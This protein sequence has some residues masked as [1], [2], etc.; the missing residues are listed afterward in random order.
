MLLAWATT[1]SSKKRT[2][3]SA[4]AIAAFISLLPRINFNPQA[5]TETKG[6]T[7]SGRVSDVQGKTLPGIFVSARNSATG[8]TTYALTQAQGIFRIPDLETGEY[9]VRVADRGW[10]GDAQRVKL[11][12]GTGSVNLTVKPD[13]IDVAEL[14]SAELLP[15]L[16]EGEG[17][18]I[19]LSNCTGCHTLQKFVTGTWDANG[20]SGIVNSMKKSFGA[21]VP[22]GKAGILSDYLNGAFAPESSLQKAAKALRFTPVKPLEVIYNAWDIPLQKSLPHTVTLDANGNGWFTDPMGSRLGYL[23]VATG[24]FKIWPTPTRNSLPHGIVVDKRGKVWFTERLQFEPANK[25]ASFDP[26]LEKFTEY[27]L[28]QNISGPHTPIFDR[29]GILWISEY[30]GNRIARF[31]PETRKFTEYT[32]PTKDAKPYGIELDKEG[33][34]W[35]AE[36]GSGSL[37][38]LDPKVG[39]VIDYPTPTKNSGVRRVRADS[40]GRIWFT[41]FLGDRLGMFDPKTERMVEFLMPGIRPQPYA[42]EVTHDDKIWLSTWHQDSMIRFDPDSKTFSTYPVP[43]LDLEIRDF[44]IDSNDTLWFVAMIPNKIVSM[45]VP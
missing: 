7:I 38:K 41:E 45:R 15:L 24:K 12:G 32:V 43:F 18:Q 29:Q 27:S 30:E 34:I 35:I 3:F 10:Q 28:P 17:K 1:M 16:P 8:R 2:V 6:Y 39:K 25:I 20:W 26:S 33:V 31:D 13:R 44:R 11:S 21:T 36:I 9:D 40:K 14:T 4:I 37:G 22:E 19:L 42:L 5:S 23:D